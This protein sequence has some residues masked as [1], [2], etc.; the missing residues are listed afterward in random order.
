[1]LE[2]NKAQEELVAFLWNRKYTL[3]D[4]GLSTKNI[5]DWSKQGLL[6]DPVKPK[7]RRKYSVVE[8]IWLKLVV[9]LREFGLSL[10]AIRN[11]RSYLLLV[12]TVDD[13]AEISKS[14]AYLNRF[15]NSDSDP[16]EDIRR[17]FD[18]HKDESNKNEIQEPYIDTETS[19]LRYI[20]T[21]ISI[22]TT[23]ALHSQKDYSLLIHSDGNCEFTQGFDYT[24]ID[25]EFL[26]QPFVH[27]SIRYLL[28]QFIQTENTIMIQEAVE[29]RFLT[30]KEAQV[31]DLLKKNQLVS[32][33]VRLNNDQEISLIETEEKVE[34][35]NRDKRLQ[36]LIMRNQY[37][38]IKC[39]SQDGSV[40]S[41]RRTTKHK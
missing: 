21:L 18:K 10:D 24:N 41:I 33:T 2:Q 25:P 29:Y 36:D 9:G 39:E 20:F 13:L 22:L 12:I 35:E 30:E 31:I 11:V 40:T 38:N 8:F 27:F 14:D 3:E 15:E 19:E 26:M 32:L 4:I 17:N 37:Q 6:L 23:D 34:L 5:F 1:M 7:S 16:L 28:N